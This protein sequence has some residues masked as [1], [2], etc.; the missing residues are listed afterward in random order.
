MTTGL[1]TQEELDRIAAQHLPPAGHE[2]REVLKERTDN[3]EQQAETQYADVGAIPKHALEPD[4]NVQSEIRRA[5]YLEIGINHPLYKTKWVNY[6]NQ[7]GSMV[8]QAKNDGWQI[9]TVREFPET[10][11]MQKADGSLRVADV[12]LMFIRHDEHLLLEQREK[13]KRLKQQYGVEAEI[14]DLAAS[15]NR[16]EGREV[17]KN[18]QTPNMT[19]VND[20]TLEVMK[21]RAAS[22]T[23]ANI[24]GNRMKE[25]FI[26]GVPLR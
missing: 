17:F 21:K 4:Y 1:Y 13:H 16:R 24:I 18:V 14:F 11:D 6:V 9:A 12:I 8:W 22:R 23:A 2:Q 15:A 7:N 5:S 19:G 3:L 25:G 20:A 10:R 26:P